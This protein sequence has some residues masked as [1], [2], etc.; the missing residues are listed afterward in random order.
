MTHGR[1][2][3]A[4]GERQIREVDVREVDRFLREL[5]RAGVSPRT[6]NK[7]RQILSAILN[8]AR[9]STTYALPTKPSRAP[10]SAAR[11]RRSPWTSMSR[12]R[13]RRL[14]ALQRRDAIAGRSRRTC[15]STRSPCAARR[16]LR[17]PSCSGSS[18]TRAAARRSRRVALERRRLRRSPT[19]R[20]TRTFRRHGDDDQGSSRSPHRPRDA[21][22]AGTRSARCPP[23]RHRARR[24]RVLQPLRRTPRPRGDPAPLQERRSS[25]RP[26]SAEAARPAPRRRQPP[27]MRGR[28]LARSRPLQPGGGCAHRQL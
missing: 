14:R 4:F 5:D 7:N 18:H 28:R 19:H 8:Y 20:A 12:R 25:R 22:R 26:S 6:V 1:L 15:P 17:T 10:T 27:R 13:S 21:C 11:R 24:V 9:R 16:T 3:A 2:M 23:R